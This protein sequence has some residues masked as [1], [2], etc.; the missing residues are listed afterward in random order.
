M[1]GTYSRPSGNTSRAT[2]S[3]D[4]PKQLS[5]LRHDTAVPNF[6]IEVSPSYENVN[7]YCNTGFYAVAAR[8]TLEALAVGASANTSIANISVKCIDVSNRTDATGVSTTTV[9]MFRLYRLTESIGQVTIHLHHT[10]RKVQVQ[11]RTLFPDNTKAPVWFVENVLKS[12]FENLSEQLA[13][14]ISGY[15]SSVDAMVPK[16]SSQP[17]P[18]TPCGGCMSLFIGR[19]SPAQCAGCNQFFHKKCLNSHKHT[20]L[21][22]NRTVSTTEQPLSMGRNNTRARLLSLVSNDVI[23]VPT[24]SMSTPT[25]LISVA[26]SNNTSAPVSNSAVITKP[27]STA[28]LPPCQTTET[29]LVSSAMGTDI[30]S[31]VS[32][33]AIPVTVPLTNSNISPS[34]ILAVP[35]PS[36]QLLLSDTASSLNPQAKVFVSNNVNPSTDTINKKQHEAKNSGKCKKKKSEPPPDLTLEYAQYQVNVTQAKIREQEVTIQDLRFKNGILESRV[37]ELEKKQ[38]E[39]I[40]K[41]YFP[42]QSSSTSEASNLQPGTGSCVS[43]SETLH[44]LSTCCSMRQHCC[45]QQSSAR[46]TSET[47][48]TEQGKQITEL[49]S[50]LATIKYKVE[51]LTEVTVPQL[52]RASNENHVNCQTTHEVPTTAH[53]TLPPNPQSSGLST[54]QQPEESLSVTVGGATS[55]PRTAVIDLPEELN[56][57]HMTIDDAI[58][59]VSVSSD[60][61]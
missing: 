41:R 5:K 57:S 1:A 40:Y 10:A 9:V 27:T 38:K 11:G 43:G 42:H 20:C 22:R 44:L 7:I 53:T 29:V 3:L 33:Q 17:K 23:S 18:S 4:R 52:I 36:S 19:S 13:G 15:N 26:P 61:N 59:D 16:K 49:K 47:W 21:N 54:V 39:E 58:A 35:G 48:I 30:R 50:D 31:S 2:F 24:P 25:A 55:S 6:E 51:L 45:Y 60:L 28:T 46:P 32:Q 12:K 56:A 34:Y 8:P 14:E 37:G